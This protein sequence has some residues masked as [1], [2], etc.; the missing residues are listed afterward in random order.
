MK[1]T[2]LIL[3]FITLS[4]IYTQE[5]QKVPFITNTGNNF[6]FGISGYTY[7]DIYITWINEIDSLYTVY[8]KKI[9]PIIS[10]DIIVSSDYQLKSNAQIV[11]GKIAWQ[12][13]DKNGWQIYLRYFSND[14]L[15]STFLISDESVNNEQMTLAN[16]RIVWSINGKLVGK[17]LNPSISDMFTIDSSNCSNPD[18]DKSFYDNMDESAIVYEKEIEGKR[19]IYYA[20]QQK[21]ESDDW[22]KS[23]IYSDGD[24]KKP[25]FHNGFL[26]LFQTKKDSVWN[27]AFGNIY[28][29]DFAI[30]SNK[31]CNYENPFI[32]DYPVPTSSARAITPFLLIFNSDSLINDTEIYAA[33]LL[34]YSEGSGDTILNISSMEGMDFEPDVCIVEDSSKYY[35][36]IFWIHE[37]NNKKDIWVA[38]TL[39]IP[40]WGDVND[41]SLNKLPFI[42]SQNFPN[43]F[44]PTTKIVF[45]IANFGFV[46]LKVYD[47]LGN[48]VS[49]LVNEEKSAGNYEVEFSANVGGSN[50]SSGIYF[51][52]LKA[53]GNRFVRKMSL[54]K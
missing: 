15:G 45:Q 35:V 22:V 43:P 42:L 18:L 13:S 29:T 34:S 19:D 1:T 7:S 52:D 54:I 11:H 25:K 6:D 14:S 30:T 24:N 36:S 31:Y 9:S 33:P 3:V 37:S 20:R 26:I 21:Y 44:N 27:I 48:E 10:K 5:F 53:G 8:V 38:R 23:S 2:I 32:F 4:T 28:S 17:E 47:I 51:C 46:S 41:K 16:S 12:V 49:T 40:A 39:F 50:L